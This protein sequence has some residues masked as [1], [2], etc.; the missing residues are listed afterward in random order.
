MYA[1]ILVFASNVRSEQNLTLLVDQLV[2]MDAAGT[3]VVP[4]MASELLRV[5]CS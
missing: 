3:D 4:K 5:G 1:Q 2:K